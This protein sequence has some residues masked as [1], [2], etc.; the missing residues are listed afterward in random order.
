MV[1]ALFDFDGTI[2]TEDCY[3]K[4]LFF[5]TP[6]TRLYVGYFILLPIIFLYKLGALPASKT[7]LILSKVAFWRR[8]ESD[9]IYKARD[10]VEQVLP[11]LIRQNMLERIQW[12]QSQGHEIFVVSASLNPYLSLWCKQHN[13]HLVC[14]EL[15]C[16]NGKY[17]GSYIHG[18]CSGTNKVDLLKKQINVS[19]YE[20]IY[21]YG[22]TEED[23]AMLSIA[24]TRV[25]QGQ[26]IN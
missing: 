11:P 16:I 9:V 5:A 12:H 20:H 8:S 10:Y 23:R 25:Y 6:K 22:D 15:E 13:I 18:D 2:T 1:L 24:D 4:F 19:N 7:R 14:S 26:Q 17:T 3:T 21:A